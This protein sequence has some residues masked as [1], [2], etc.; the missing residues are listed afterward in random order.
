M[1]GKIRGVKFVPVA[2]GWRSTA[3][4]FAQQIA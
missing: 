3:L 4:Q 2:E 1:G